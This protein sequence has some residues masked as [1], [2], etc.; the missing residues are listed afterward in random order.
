[1]KI[2]V[3]GNELSVL[4]GMR[5]LLESQNYLNIIVEIHKGHHLSQGI[6]PKEVYDFLQKFGFSAKQITS[7]KSIVLFNNKKV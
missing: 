2:D 6:E 1:M 3:E 7:N 5:N 4:K